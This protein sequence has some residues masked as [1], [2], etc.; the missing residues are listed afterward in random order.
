MEH[1]ISNL[2]EKGKKAKTR[3]TKDILRAM[4]TEANKRFI[5]EYRLT[6]A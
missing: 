5:E 3:K 1:T 4:I 6:L 2:F